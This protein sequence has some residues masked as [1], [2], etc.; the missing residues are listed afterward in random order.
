MCGLFESS[1][2]VSP[3]FFIY[4]PFDDVGVPFEPLAAMFDVARQPGNA[5]SV[6]NFPDALTGETRRPI[7]ARRPRSCALDIPAFVSR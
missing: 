1:S 6:R 2:A 3:P 4:L 7:A 5:D